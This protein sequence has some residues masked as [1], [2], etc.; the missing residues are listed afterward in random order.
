[1]IIET[2]NSTRQVIWTL[3]CSGSVK[4]TLQV[5]WTLLFRIRE[6]NFTSDIYTLYLMISEMDAIMYAMYMYL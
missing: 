6:I 3:Y 2:D 1:M 5:T 4:Q